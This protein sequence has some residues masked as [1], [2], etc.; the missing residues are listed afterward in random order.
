MA[1]M[2]HCIK[3]DEHYIFTP[4]TLQATYGTQFNVLSSI[5]TPTHHQNII[6][7]LPFRQINPRN[8]HI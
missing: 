2:K 4:A 3:V 6:I 5:Y 1:I 7:S 8:N